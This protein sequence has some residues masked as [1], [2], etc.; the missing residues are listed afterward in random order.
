MSRIIISPDSFKGTI[1]GEEAA[2]ALRDGWSSVAPDD[3]ILLLPQADGGEGTCDVIANAVPDAEWK[4]TAE[5]VTGPDGRPVPGRWIVLPSGEAVVELAIPSG[6]PLMKVKDPRGAQ[7]RGLGQVL[8]AAVQAGASKLSI[9]LGGSA[10]TDG[11]VGALRELGV[12]FLTSDGHEIGEGGRGLM[13]LASIDSSQMVAPPAGGVRLLCDG[14]SPLTGPTGSAAIFGPQKGATPTDVAYLDDALAHLAQVA[15]GEP[16]YPGTGA[17]GG[18]AYGLMVLWGAS[19]VSGAQEVA[20]L[21][22]L[23]EELSHADMAIT[24]EGSFDVSSLAG[25]AVATIIDAA[26]Q[27]HTPCAVVAGGFTP[28]GLAALDARGIARVSLTEL[29]GHA[30]RAMAEPAHFLAQAGAQLAGDFH[31]H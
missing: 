16:D 7:T 19:I 10:S 27:T 22:G 18:T 13:E 14:T 3:E 11:G 29:A 28:E 26:A 17:A 5:P 30:S 4:S 2:R 9:G 31:A 24:G 12:H 8:K 20:K 15:G 6:L 21:T 23:S 1:T 25:K